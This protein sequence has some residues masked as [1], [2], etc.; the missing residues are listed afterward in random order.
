MLPVSSFPLS[1]LSTLSR[2][3]HQADETAGDN[4]SLT[5]WSIVEVYTAVICS[6]LIPIRPLIMKH[7]P[8]LPSITN[9]FRT[10]SH[11]YTSP[12]I[13]R[14]ISR[15]SRRTV[16]LP[17]DS[18]TGFGRER[19]EGW[20]DK[21]LPRLPMVGPIRKTTETHVVRI[22]MEEIEREEMK[23]HEMR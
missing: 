2:S 1:P 19:L 12:P 9:L 3:D 5:L 8:E 18:E 6:C 17:W 16:Q 7:I 20:E 10:H 11:T 13:R 22:K 15:W 23:G 21:P 4:V 14:R